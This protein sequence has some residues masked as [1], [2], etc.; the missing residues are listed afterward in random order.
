M[1]LKTRLVLDIRLDPTR[2][3]VKATRRVASDMKT[4][5]ITRRYMGSFS[6]YYVFVDPEVVCLSD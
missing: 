2:T 3:P 6:Y 4:I 1:V 5:S